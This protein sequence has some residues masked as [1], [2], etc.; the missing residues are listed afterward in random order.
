VVVVVSGTPGRLRVPTSRALLHTRRGRFAYSSVFACS[1]M[2]A[3]SSNVEPR[4]LEVDCSVSDSYEIQ[5][6]QPMEGAMASWFDFG[7]STPG[8]I[9]ALSLL[10]IPEGRCGSTTA[11]VLTAVGHTDWGAGFGEYQTA[12]APVDA[13]DYEGVAFWARAPT[14]HTST[15]FLLTLNDRNTSVSGM[16]CV[17]P[18]VDVA[19]GAYTYNEAGMIVPVGG[20]L[21][22]PEDCG[23]GFMRVVTVSRQ[24]QLYLLPFESFQQLAQPNRIPTGI[25]RSAIYQFT[26]N[27]PKDSIIE[28]WID[29]L[30]VYRRRM[31]APEPG[32]S[33]EPEI[34]R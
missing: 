30:G 20:E 22:A 1:S 15:A 14:D 32:A 16:V 19:D 11:L 10:P 33:A 18:V 12:M 3:C 23:N 17:E 31:D 7:D 13:T 6:L 2:F 4:N 34:Q 21:P 5:V 27:I 26:V 8:A 28:L 9:R 25:D 24:W 29:D